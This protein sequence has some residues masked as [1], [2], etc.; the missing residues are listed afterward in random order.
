MV[1]GPATEH[2]AREPAPLLDDRALLDLS[3]ASTPERA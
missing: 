1:N 2:E 3:A